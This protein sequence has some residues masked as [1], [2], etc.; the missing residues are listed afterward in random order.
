[1]NDRYV[2]LTR[3]SLKK[4]TYGIHSLD[5]AQRELVRAELQPY[6]GKQLWENDLRHLLHE[7]K[8][9]HQLSSIDIEALKEAFFTESH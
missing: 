3:D 9:H 6:V 2:I 1:M 5:Q 4:I 8:E 7:F